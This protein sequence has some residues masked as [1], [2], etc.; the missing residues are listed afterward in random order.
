[1]ERLEQSNKHNQDTCQKN[2]FF[3]LTFILFTCTAGLH[4]QGAI[5]L[6]AISGDHM[7]LQRDKPIPVWGWSGE[8][9]EVKVSFARQVRYR[10]GRKRRQVGG[11]P[12]HH[13]SK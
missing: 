5:E 12:T 7:V 13:E 4:L 3:H 11:T 8:G 10:N 1:V 2:T 6:P 9:Q